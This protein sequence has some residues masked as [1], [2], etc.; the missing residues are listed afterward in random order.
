[1]DLPPTICDS[2]VRASFGVPC[3]S[4]VFSNPYETQIGEVL[5][6]SPGPVNESAI[7]AQVL[8]Y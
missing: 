1:M 8:A 3:D 2:P 4:E 7:T 5:L 6:A